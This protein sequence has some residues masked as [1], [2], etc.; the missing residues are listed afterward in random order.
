MGFRFRKSIK[1]LPGIKLNLSKKSSS[2]TVGKPG[3]CMNISS[4]GVK[5]T[6]GLPGTGISYTSNLSSSKKEKK[7][8]QNNSKDYSQDEKGYLIFECFALILLFPFF[9]GI[10]KILSC[11]INSFLL[12]LIISATF[13][14]FWGIFYF[15]ILSFCKYKTITFFGILILLLCFDYYAVQYSK[16]FYAIKQQET[17]NFKKPNENQIYVNNQQKATNYPICTPLNDE[18]KLCGSNE[19]VSFMKKYI[20][21]CDAE[22]DKLMGITESKDYR[23]HSNIKSIKSTKYPNAKYAI[24][25]IKCDYSHFPLKD[26]PGTE[27]TLIMDGSFQGIVVL[28]EALF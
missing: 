14:I 8:I 21:I 11:H 13:I 2:I 26:M 6:I 20:N 22:F 25:Y 5:S 23:W 9:Y 24:K 28:D 4:K 7:Y 12:G 17:I 18:F 1:I 16:S 27:K 10:Y 19:K 15:M 3:A